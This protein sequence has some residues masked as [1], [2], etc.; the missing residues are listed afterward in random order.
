MW[1]NN[2]EQNKK[3]SETSNI[4]FH[5]QYKMFDPIV[6]YAA[7]TLERKRRRLEWIPRF[8]SYVLTLE[9]KGFRLEIGLQPILERRR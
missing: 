2:L 6:L 8:P 3:I 4:H 5:Q 1:T 9:G 7:I